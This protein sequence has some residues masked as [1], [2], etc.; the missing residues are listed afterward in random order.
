MKIHAF[1]RVETQRRES[2]G[3]GPAFGQSINLNDPRLAASD[4]ISL[5]FGRD[6][7]AIRKAFVESLKTHGLFVSGG[8]GTMGND[9]A[10]NAM[11]FGLPVYAQDM[12]SKKDLI[13]A[14]MK[15][16][17]DK[18]VSKGVMSREEADANL[19][20]LRAAVGTLKD[21]PDQTPKNPAM[22]IEAIPEV[23]NWKTDLFAN[24][25]KHMGPDTILAT[26]TSS[27]SVNELAAATGRPDRFVGLHYFLPA[28]QNRFIEVIPGDKTSPETL[29]K[30]LAFVK[31]VGK[32]P[33][34]SKDS[35]GF[36]VNRVGVPLINEGIRLYDELKTGDAEKDKQ[37]ATYI[38][39]VAMETM[40]PGA[41]K[42]HF[43]FLKKKVL[44]P[45][46]TMNR[47][48]YMGLIGEITEILDKGLSGKYADSYKPAGTILEKL[49][50][51]KQVRGQ[52]GEKAKAAGWNEEQVAE[53]MQ[54]EIVPYHIPVAKER[55]DI[56]PAIRQKIQDRLLGA[57][58]GVVGQLLDEE[59][60]RL[61][62]IERGLKTGLGWEAGPFELMNE[63]GP[64]KALKL[65]EDYAKLRPGFGVPESLKAQAAKGEP[66]RLEFVDSRREGSTTYL[67]INK[68][69]RNNAFDAAILT[70]IRDKFKAAEADPDTQT[71]VMES[72]GGKNFAAGADLP[73]L[74]QTVSDLQN[75]PWVKA[76]PETITI[77]GM[78]KVP[79]KGAVVYKR[80]IEPFLTQGF[81][82]M[83][84]IASSPKVTVAKVNGNALGG[85]SEI[86]LACDYI[87]AAE[88]ANMGLPEV[89]YGIFP[90]WGGTER[91]PE[92]IGQGLAKWM[93]LNGG[94]MGRG[95]KGPAILNGKDAFT[96]GL[97]D[98]VVPD[99][100]LDAAVKEAVESGE[101]AEKPVRTGSPMK[102]LPSK[103]TTL[104]YRYQSTPLAE[105]IDTDL[106]G[107]Y[108][109]IADNE[110]R[111]K[112]KQAY[113]RV[114]GLASRRVEQ[115]LKHHPAK[116]LQQMVQ[117][118]QRVDSLTRAAKKA[119]AAAKKES[120]GS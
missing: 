84:E 66:F 15:K 33:I 43:D 6:D 50:Q 63:I 31:A 118:M 16:S 29:Q 34:V 95:G 36:V 104:Q 68:P 93:I 105:L 69:Q 64:K 54:Q 38:D 79:V 49:G 22:V 57:V 20:R 40:W 112:L 58:F 56:P 119:E 92:R 106:K 9:I 111:G 42:T 74:M 78:G 117:N 97:V 70:E 72:V 82:L 18:A 47:A 87:V 3:A 10:M 71:I 99:T 41:S 27:L 46:G 53:A 21:E 62:D 28:N 107:Y 91:L 45:I 51:F 110:L 94:F 25:D 65:V 116:D 5:R 75:K 67:T 2:A 120:K 44:L 98:K 113:G 14:K 48:E 8:A 114:L 77:P 19:S 4:S 80:A 26:N 85:G 59:V 37:L 12:T 13:V 96:I 52:V 11:N 90:A 61:G 35:P 7:L 101:F 24:L 109:T 32:T 73:W 55:V 30:A 89:K 108:D 100:D 83:K 102:E 39:Q 17:Y 103:W 88:S 115:G 81:D 1:P 86:A 76:L 60:A 23:L